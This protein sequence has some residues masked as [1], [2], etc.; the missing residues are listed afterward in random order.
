MF[1]DSPSISGFAPSSPPL[2]EMRGSDFR[3][4]RVQASISISRFDCISVHRPLDFNFSPRS[5]AFH[6]EMQPNPRFRA[7]ETTS[8]TQK[9]NRNLDFDFNPRFQKRVGYVGKQ[10]CDD[11]FGMN[12]GFYFDFKTELSTSANLGWVR[13]CVHLGAKLVGV[14]LV[15]AGDSVCIWVQSWV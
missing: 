14:G 15:K 7:P 4:V 10:T 11:N 9:C 13:F 1:Q 12:S 2:P 8:L 6:T 3:N 5:D